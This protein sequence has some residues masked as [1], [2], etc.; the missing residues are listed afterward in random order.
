MV[1]RIEDRTGKVLAEF[2]PHPTEQA[3]DEAD[4]YALIDMMRGVVDKGT[5]PRYSPPLG[6]SKMTWRAKPVPRKT[7]Q[8]AGLS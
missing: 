4:S 7:M 1:T 2:A 8:M 6:H 5:G 3:M